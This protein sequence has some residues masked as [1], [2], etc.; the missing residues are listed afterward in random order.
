[1]YESHQV[2]FWL[3]NCLHSIWNVKDLYIVGHD[4]SKFK[5]VHSSERVETG[6]RVQ[7]SFLRLNL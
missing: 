1:M 7:G 4:L 3:E 2:K 6:A 5:K